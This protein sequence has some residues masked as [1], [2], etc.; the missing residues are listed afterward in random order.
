MIGITLRQQAIHHAT[1]CGWSS[2]SAKTVAD[3]AVEVAESNFPILNS[4]HFGR[5]MR[6]AMQVDAEAAH[7]I[8]EKGQQ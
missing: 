7:G 2:D 3:I 8:T 4:A 1:S 5:V 6:E